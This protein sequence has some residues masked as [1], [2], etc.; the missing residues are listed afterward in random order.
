MQNIRAIE[1]D[2][3]NTEE[4]KAEPLTML[5]VPANNTTKLVCQDPWVSFVLT[6]VTIIDW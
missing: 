3:M 2:A 6:A 5:D 1:A 4:G